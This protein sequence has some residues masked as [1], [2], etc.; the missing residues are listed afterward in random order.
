MGFAAVPLD[1]EP[2]LAHC[3][4]MGA[5][6]DEGHIR[7]GLGERSAVGPANAAGADHRDAH[8]ILLNQAG[9]E[10]GGPIFPGGK[11]RLF[12]RWLWI[13]GFLAVR[14]RLFQHLSDPT[15]H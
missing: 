6:R 8:P 2:V 4:E 15:F 3:R 11:H 12:A 1:T 14:W 9:W 5:A 13:I 10:L 7:T